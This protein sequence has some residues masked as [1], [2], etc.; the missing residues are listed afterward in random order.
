MFRE[1]NREIG[2]PNLI[3]N[4]LSISGFGGYSPRVRTPQQD[5]A[6]PTNARPGIHRNPERTE[7]AANHAREHTHGGHTHGVADASVR[8]IVAACAITTIVFLAELIGGWLSGSIALLADAM[9]MISDAAGLFIAL[10][11]VV[12]GNRPA[13]QTATFGYRRAEV[14]AALV[15]AVAVLFIS[16][17]IVVEAIRRLHSPDAVDVPIMIAIAVIGLLANA[18]SAWI[19]SR[20]RHRSLNVKG[21]YLHVLVDLAGSV[22]VIA[23]GIVIQFTGFVFADVIASLVIAALVLPRAW[24]LLSQSLR[25]LLEQV[26]DGF[27]ADAVRPALLAVEGVVDVHDVHL[28][29][30]DGTSVLASAHLVVADGTATSTAA[31][32]ILENAQSALAQLGI[33][34]ATIQIERPEHQLYDS[35][36]E[37]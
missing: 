37:N 16:A 19:L 29:S 35:I 28:W 27:N 6:R 26:P 34:H 31:P 32:R 11:A 2:I 15:N 3:F 13:N 25:I 21:A 18:L 1:L 17:F 20:H 24:Q 7:H 30:V 5:P 4:K 10:I 14:L 12:A 36:C 22:A 8:A 33:T 23:A 9:H